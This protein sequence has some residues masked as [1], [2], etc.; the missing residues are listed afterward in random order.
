MILMSICY[1][2][3]NSIRLRTI[4]LKLYQE[5][6]GGSSDTSDWMALRPISDFCRKSTEASS[7]WA[8][9]S[10]GLFRVDQVKGDDN[11]RTSRPCRVALADWALR[12]S[13]P[14]SE[15]VRFLPSLISTIEFNRFHFISCIM[16]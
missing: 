12:I 15:L 9:V 14:A 6:I 4:Q 7:R 3:I 8:I 11:R 10:Q 5:N 16:F 13:L 1:L 2:K